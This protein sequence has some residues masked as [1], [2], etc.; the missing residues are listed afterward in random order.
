M[1]NYKIV[2]NDKNYR[3]GVSFE[4]EYWWLSE[5]NSCD[6][7]YIIYEVL[8]NL[9]KVIVGELSEY[10]FGYDATIIDFYIDRSIINYG[11]GILFYARMAGPDSKMER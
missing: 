3:P 8:P 1:I 5:L 2:S 4:N 6:T 11:Y 7:D 9:D 10:E